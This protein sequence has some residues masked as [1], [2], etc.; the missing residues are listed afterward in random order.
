LF[1]KIRQSLGKTRRQLAAAVGTGNITEETWEEMEDTLVRSD[2]GVETTIELVDAVRE[3]AEAEA[4]INA[5]D[6][7]PILKSEMRKRLINSA[8]FA[9]GQRRQLTVVMVVGVNGSGKT[10]SIGKLASYYKDE[11]NVRLAAGDTFRAGAIDQLKV[12]AER[13]GV[14]ITASQPGSDAAAL[15][16][17]SIRAARAR[18]VDPGRKGALLFVDT[19]GRLKTNFNLMRELEK[20]YNVC[21]SSVHGA[22]HETLIVIDAP[23]GQNALEQAKKFKESVNLTGVILTKLDGTGKGGMIFSIYRELG[24]PVRFVGTG[25]AIDD[26]VPFDADEFIDGMFEE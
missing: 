23:T 12:W 10:T 17:D 4:I 19:A 22:P 15:I 7:T 11:Y 5:E 24:I 20:V 16:Y 9:I 21:A 1:K 14:P 18:D 26:L 13:A 2:L 3:R 25:E 6:L 8:E